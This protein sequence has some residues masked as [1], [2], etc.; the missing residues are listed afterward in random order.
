MAY[1]LVKTE[2]NTYSIADFR[3]EK[4]TPWDGVRNYQARNYLRAMQPG[5][6]VFFYHSVVDPVG[7]VGLAKVKRNAYPDPTQFDKESAY[8]D[9]KASKENPRWFSPDLEFIKA[10]SAP[11]ALE[12][13]R[14]EQAL[15][16][17][18]LLQKGSR[19]SVQP[20]SEKEFKFIE[21]LVR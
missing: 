19:L 17:M 18:V 12:E 9:G 14:K 15:Q 8:F 7:I 4:V 20:V 2:P 10:Y 16:S 5:E 11:L 13:L 3:R 21:K 6:L 1:W